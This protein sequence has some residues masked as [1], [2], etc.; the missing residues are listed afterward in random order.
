MPKEALPVCPNCEFLQ[1][2]ILCDKKSGAVVHYM[3]E[4]LLN[5]VLAAEYKTALPE[6]RLLV[7]VLV[8]TRR[9]LEAQQKA[10]SVIKEKAKIKSNMLK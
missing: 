8:R 9:A 7:N 10:R 3:L 6:E 4:N 2:F 5:K 1:R